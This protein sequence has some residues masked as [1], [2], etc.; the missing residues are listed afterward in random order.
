MG[1]LFVSGKFHTH[2]EDFLRKA[3]EQCIEG[4]TVLG[5]AYSEE[6]LGRALAVVAKVATDQLVSSPFIY[7]PGYYVITGLLRLHSPSVV[8]TTL[9]D[10]WV[11]VRAASCLGLDCMWPVCEAS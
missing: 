6:K 2:R 10:A 9:R 8:W 11:P 4:L 1:Q 7:T 3:L 5:L